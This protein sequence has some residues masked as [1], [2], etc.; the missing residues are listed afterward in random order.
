MFC[1]AQQQQISI[2]TAAA[3]SPTDLSS[4]VLAALY[5]PNVANVAYVAY[6]AYPPPIVLPNPNR[7]C[8]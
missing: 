5:A 6:A 4:T 7:P 3:V 8:L 1:Y 2:K